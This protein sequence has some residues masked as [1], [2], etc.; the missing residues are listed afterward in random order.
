[1]NNLCIH[2]VKD[3]FVKQ[4]DFSDFRTFTL[5][6]RDEDNKPF[7]IELFTGLKTE[8]DFPVVVSDND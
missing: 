8:L 2:N 6:V 7:Q 3:V 4:K 5:I 1:M